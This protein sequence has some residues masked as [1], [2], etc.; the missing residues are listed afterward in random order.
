M[1]IMAA[2]RRVHRERATTRPWPGLVQRTTSIPLHSPSIRG[3][4]P[5]QVRNLPHRDLSAN[6]VEVDARHG[7]SSLGDAT[8][9]CSRTV[10]FP[11]FSLWATGTA[12]SIDGF[13]RCQPAGGRQSRPA[14]SSDSSTSPKRSFLTPERIARLRSRERHALVHKVKHLLLRIASRSVLE[15]RDTGRSS[16]RSGRRW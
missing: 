10:P 6:S 4:E 14:R 13:R 1:A 8:S 3:L 12:P 2:D 11:L 5:K 16:E 7:C 9:R 15:L